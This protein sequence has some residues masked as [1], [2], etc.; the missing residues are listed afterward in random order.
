MRFYDPEFGQVLIDGVDVKNYNVNE[1][2]Q[3]MGLVMQEPTLFNYTIR[4]NILYGKMKASNREVIDA[5]TIANAMEFIEGEALSATVDDDV[6]AIAEAMKS[7]LYKEE[8]I[9]IMGEKI[10][11]ETKDSHAPE[12]KKDEIVQR[13]G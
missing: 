6:T 3:R 5:A 11:E 1:L 8:L 12:D 9:R 2:R 4:E 7:E 13:L 10:F